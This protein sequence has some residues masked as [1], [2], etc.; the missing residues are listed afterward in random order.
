M[1]TKHIL[2]GLGFLAAG[3]GVCFYYRKKINQKLDLKNSIDTRGMSNYEIIIP[4]KYQNE[5]G[6]YYESISKTGYSYVSEMVSS[7]DNKNP[8]KIIVDI[9]ATPEIMKKI[10]DTLKGLNQEIIIE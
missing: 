10:S 8:I 1:K 4:F 5:I 9:K 7:D 6:N 3:I 2:I